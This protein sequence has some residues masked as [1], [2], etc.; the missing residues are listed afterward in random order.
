MEAIVTLVIIAAA[1]ALFVAQAFP[2]VITSLLVVVALV[3]TRI[4]PPDQALAGFANNTTLLIL[5]M[6]PL[7]EALF[8]TGVGD[9]LGQAATRYAGQNQ[10]KL[11]LAVVAVVILLSSVT[12]N[13]GATLSMLPLTVA[14]ARMVS[15]NPK[16]LL[17]PM[18]LGASLGGNLTLVGRAPNMIIND[19]SARAGFGTFGF[20][21]FA[22]IGLPIAVAGTLFLVFGSSRL[23]PDHPDAGKEA[24]P[25]PEF[26]VRLEK[27]PAALAIFLGVVAAMVL[28]S[29]IR[30]WTGMDLTMLALAGSI[31]V[32]LAGC[33]TIEE[34]LESI[35][36]QSVFIFA[37]LIPLG[38]AMTGTGAAN[39]VSQLMLGLL[40][41]DNYLL[42]TA[43]L[44][45]VG[46]ILAQFLSHTA[47]ASILAPVYL[48][49]AQQLGVSPM[50]LLMAL[51]MG[52]G[53]AMAT[54][55]G[56]PPNTIVYVR[57]GYRFTDFVLAGGP[58]LLIG[59]AIG[60]VLIPL[61]FPY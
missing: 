29:R 32:V 33:I 31:L 38:Q 37:C 28:E 22:F 11:T 53:V 7:G 19:V 6:S 48:A 54:P 1:I 36:W 47:A 46:G 43:G 42:L 45:L 55:I 9:L 15:M 5:F 39:M 30:A 40:P 60:A 3:A 17:L 50:P 59:V 52:T 12:S 13:T 16:R 20:F 27:R 25:Q 34:Y 26:E 8:R 57:G 56:T 23:F 41:D 49:M 51:S 35:D 21:D 61:F 44:L 24:V 58:I 10:Q 18:A 4:L 14:V 2:I